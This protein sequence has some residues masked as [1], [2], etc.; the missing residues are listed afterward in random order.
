MNI[1]DHNHEEI[2]YE[3]KYCP[4]C[5]TITEKNQEIKDLEKQIERLEADISRLESEGE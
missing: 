1:C 5:D 3:G 4:L 2:C